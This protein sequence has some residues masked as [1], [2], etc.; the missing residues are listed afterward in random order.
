MSFHEQEG[1]YPASRS[2]LEVSRVMHCKSI[3]L[4]GNEQSTV[5]Q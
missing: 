2:T 1:E 5:M 4:R 3:P